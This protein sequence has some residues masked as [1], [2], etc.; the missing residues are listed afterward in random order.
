MRIETDIYDLESDI[1]D[2]HNKMMVRFVGPN[3]KT[4]AHEYIE[5]RKEIIKLREQLRILNKLKVREILM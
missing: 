5:M 3:H 4:D 2:S 1:Y